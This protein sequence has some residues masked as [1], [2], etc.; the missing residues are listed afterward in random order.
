MYTCT[1]VCE[2]VSLTVFIAEHYIVPPPH[3]PYPNACHSSAI[4]TTDEAFITLQVLLYSGTT[5]T[6]FKMK[7]ILVCNMP[8]K[9]AIQASSI[10]S[11][12]GVLFSKAPAFVG[13]GVAFC[14][15]CLGGSRSPRGC[16]HRSGKRGSNSNG[17]RSNTLL[18]DLQASIGGLDMPLVAL[19]S[20]LTGFD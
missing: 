5:Q 13:R 8:R 16:H 3:Y 11:P 19:W 18:S 9:I 2:D 10:N 17:R 4:S 15:Q 20:P 7:D 1:C 6:A 14:V 12:Y